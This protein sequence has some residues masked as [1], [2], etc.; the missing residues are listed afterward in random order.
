MVLLGGALALAATGTGLA[1]IIVVSN[2]TFAIC[3]GALPLRFTLRAIAT[4]SR[5]FVTPAVF[6]RTVRP[7]LGIVGARYLKNGLATR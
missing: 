1:A 3:Q 6:A 2:N 7:A 4:V 5:A